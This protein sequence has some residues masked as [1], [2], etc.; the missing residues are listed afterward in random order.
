MNKKI[1]TYLLY[2]LGI[3]VLLMIIPGNGQKMASADNFAM[4]NTKFACTS[5][6]TCPVCI[7]EVFSA[8]KSAT[9]VSGKCVLPDTCLYWDCGKTEGC[10]SIRQTILDNTI[11]KFNQFPWLLWALIGV[12]VTYILLWVDKG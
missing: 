12:I 9:C 2:A 6:A 5:A 7:D 8:N 10:H 3:I 4:V 1:S 11:Q